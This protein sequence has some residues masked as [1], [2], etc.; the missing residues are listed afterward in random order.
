MFR[1]IDGAVE[2]KKRDLVKGGEG[3]DK[4]NRAFTRFLDEYFPEGKNLDFQ[5]SVSGNSIIIQ[6][7]NKTVANELI[8]KM[9]DL[10]RVFKEERINPSQIVIR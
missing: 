9:T 6:S 7:S 1:N 2:R 3:E 8:L 5:V 4:L 10:S